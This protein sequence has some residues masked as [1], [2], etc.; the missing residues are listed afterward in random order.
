MGFDNTDVHNVVGNATLAVAL[1]RLQP[2][3]EELDR[4]IDMQQQLC[5]GS[6]FDMPAGYHVYDDLPPIEQQFSEH[7]RIAVGSWGEVRVSRMWLFGSAMF[8]VELQN[9]PNLRMAVLIESVFEALLGQA[10]LGAAAIGRIY[11]PS[12]QPKRLV[13][14]E[15]IAAVGVREWE[16]LLHSLG[17][18][19]EAQMLLEARVAFYAQTQ[20]AE[21]NGLDVSESTLGEAW[22]C[23]LLSCEAAPAAMEEMA[24]HYRACKVFLGMI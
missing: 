9:M 11:F 16:Q 10:L 5:L 22:Q 19:A 3:S 2:A 13:Y 17:C 12:I 23:F 8:Y 18:T 24:R 4:L 7:I 20:E 21:R 14:A 6:I 1:G 15:P